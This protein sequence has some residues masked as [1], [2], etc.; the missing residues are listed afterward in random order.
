MGLGNL[1]IAATLAYAVSM[2]S[3]WARC[4]DYIPQP[5]PQNAS[6]DI[7]GQDLDT[8]QERGFITFAAYEDF[9]PWSWED[10]GKITGVDI[11]IGRLIAEELGVE[12]RFNLV[13]AGEDLATDL[14]NWL[15]K[16]PIVGGQVANVM[17]HVP[18]DSEFACRVEQV[19]FTGQYHTEEIAIA[20]RKD[21]Y[22]E[23]PPLPA[24]FRFDTV[25]VENDSIADF[26]LSS[27][28]GGQLSQNVTRYP[29]MSEAMA[30]LDAGNTMAAMGPRAQLEFGLTDATDVHVPPLPG[31]AVGSWDIGVG[32]HFAYR[33]LAY[34]V[35]DAIFAALQD[36]RMDAIFTRYGLTL[37]PPELR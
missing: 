8:I 35:G 32:V 9:P 6:R 2:S 11:E 16:G 14:R 17:L 24:Y 15:W 20:Y 31:F 33:P 28:P 5:K 22:P 36:G 34:A 23:D 7:V 27:F 13:A 29:T 37:T 10:G 1:Y 12:A 26:Y 30:G 18:Y 19:V 3:A 25:G 21:D 4:A